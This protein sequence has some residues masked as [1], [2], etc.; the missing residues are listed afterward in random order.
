MHD[1]VMGIWWLLRKHS[2]PFFSHT[3]KILFMDNATKW[4]LSL[5]LGFWVTDTC[6]PLIELSGCFVPM[7]PPSLPPTLQPVTEALF[8]FPESHSKFPLAACFTHGTVNFYVTLSIHLPSP[9][10]PPPMSTGLFS[11]S[12]SP[13]PPW[14]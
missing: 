4:Y 12:V 14:K 11:M 9:S 3:K 8:D 1:L 13:L 7:S 10:S 6:L 2:F 5:T